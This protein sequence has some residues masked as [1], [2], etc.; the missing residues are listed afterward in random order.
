LP[1][2]T[3][4][5]SGGSQWWLNNNPFLK[6][7][8]TGYISYFQDEAVIIPEGAEGGN[9]GGGDTGTV[10]VPESATLLLVGAGLLGLAGFR[11]KVKN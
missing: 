1:T 7:E 8:L 11:R 4:V 6:D 2:V 3:L 10:D 9:T 5:P